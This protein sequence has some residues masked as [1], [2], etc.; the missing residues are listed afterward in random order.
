MIFVDIGMAFIF[1]I[2]FVVLLTLANTRQKRNIFNKPAFS[3][4]GKKDTQEIKKF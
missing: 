4:S 2:L 1:R 3:T